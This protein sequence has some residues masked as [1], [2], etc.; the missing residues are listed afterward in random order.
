MPVREVEQRLRE[1]SKGKSAVVNV[2][3][4]ALEVMPSAVA[5]SLAASR[6]YRL[7]ALL[8]R[9]KFCTFRILSSGFPRHETQLPPLLSRSY[10]IKKRGARVRSAYQL[11]GRSCSRCPSDTQL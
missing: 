3:I 10:Y 7:S 6:Q 9:F 11:L 2:T 8:T 4:E 5:R 1:P